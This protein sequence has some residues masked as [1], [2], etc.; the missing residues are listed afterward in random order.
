MSIEGLTPG[1]KYN[2]IGT[3]TILLIA[4][5]LNL[6]ISFSCVC[7]AAI[8]PIFHILNPSPISVTISAPYYV[9]IIIYYLITDY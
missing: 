5:V 8:H 7:A 2:G 4:C 3:C 9:K 1:Q 6:P